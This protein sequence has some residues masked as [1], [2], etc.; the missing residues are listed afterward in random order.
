MNGPSHQKKME[1]SVLHRIFEKK[2]HKHPIHNGLKSDRVLRW[3]SL[4]EECGPETHC[5]KGPENTVAE[6]LSRNP[7]KPHVVPFS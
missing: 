6:T 3:R 7:E 1:A 5:I 2:D 4:M